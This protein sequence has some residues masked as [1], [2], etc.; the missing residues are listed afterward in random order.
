MWKFKVRP[1]KALTIYQAKINLL[2][3]VK[4][5]QHFFVACGI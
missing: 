1:L 5:V 4:T 3:T 2:F